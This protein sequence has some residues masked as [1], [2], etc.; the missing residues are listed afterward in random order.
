MGLGAKV[1]IIWAPLSG[2]MPGRVC[3]QFPTNLG[4]FSHRGLLLLGGFR[5]NW[6]HGLADSY[7]WNIDVLADIVC[8]IPVFLVGPKY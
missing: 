6:D 4:F 7:C 1:T 3:I 8:V 5:G 2:T